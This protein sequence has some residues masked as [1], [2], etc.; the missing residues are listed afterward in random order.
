MIQHDADFRCDVLERFWD[1]G[2]TKCEVSEMFWR[3]F[4]GKSPGLPRS[5]LLDLTSGA[6]KG[7]R[8]AKQYLPWNYLVNTSYAI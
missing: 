4:E 3:Y 8:E 6:Y 2:L 1:K 5:L 7:Q